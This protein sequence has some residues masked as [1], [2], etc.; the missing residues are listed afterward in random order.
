MEQLAADPL[1]LLVDVNLGCVSADVGPGQ[2]ENFAT[3]Q[4][5]DEDQDV[6]GVQ[7][8]LGV[9]GGLKEPACFVYA[10]RFA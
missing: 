5:Q 4:A 6:C 1:Q 2:P 3:P 9:A 8:I 10:P 7:R